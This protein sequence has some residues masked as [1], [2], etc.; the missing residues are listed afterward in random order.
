MRRDRVALRDL[1]GSVA[2]SDWLPPEQNYDGEMAVCISGRDILDSGTFYR[3]LKFV[4]VE[5]TDDEATDDE[6]QATAASSSSAAMLLFTSRPA[7]IAAITACRH[8]S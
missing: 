2:E 6:G 7:T 8:R 5:R 1:G 4:V 3:D